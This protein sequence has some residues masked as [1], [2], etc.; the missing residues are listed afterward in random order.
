M[1]LCCAALPCDCFAPSALQF[2]AITAAPLNQKASSRQLE[3]LPQPCQGGRPTQASGRGRGSLRRCSCRHVVTF[4]CDAIGV[5]AHATHG[6]ALDGEAAPRA[7]GGIDAA[8][9]NV[10]RHTSHITHHTSHVTCGELSSCGKRNS[11]PAA[12]P[13]PPPPPPPQLARCPQGT[14]CVPCAT[15]GRA[16]ATL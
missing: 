1:L 14:A 7:V 15:A 2:I 11:R 8:E 5:R 9:V 3:T 12:A 16:C 4:D 10:T 6:C 13:H